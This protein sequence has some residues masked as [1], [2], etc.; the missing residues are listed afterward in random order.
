[1][2]SPVVGGKVHARAAHTSAVRCYSL[3]NG[4]LLSRLSKRTG[5]QHRMVGEQ[6]FL[7]NFDLVVDKIRLPQVR[8]LLQHHHAKSIRGQRLGQNATGSAG[9]N[10]HE[11]DFVGVLVL[12]L[13][14]GHFV[15]GAGLSGC[16]PG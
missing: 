14:C 10:D 8:T 16:Q 3:R 7:Q 2:K 11:I 13:G 15:C 4:F 5:L 6:V 1:M 12:D 9:A